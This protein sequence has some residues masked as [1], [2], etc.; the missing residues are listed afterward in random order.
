VAP[1]PKRPLLE[2]RQYMGYLIAACPIKG[3]PR[4]PSWNPDKCFRN[5]PSVCLP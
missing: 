5:L 1:V 3:P 4:S 2:T